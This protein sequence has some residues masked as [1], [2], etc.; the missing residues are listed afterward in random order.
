MDKIPDND[1]SAVCEVGRQRVTEGKSLRSWPWAKVMDLLRR[2]GHSIK[3]LANRGDNDSKKLI[4]Y[5]YYASRH[6]HDLT[7]NYDLRDAFEIWLRRNCNVSERLM[8][9]NKYGYLVGAAND[10]DAGGAA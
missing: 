2:Y 1:S 10:D 9:A 4:E 7:A 6:P 3:L 5:Y 8:L